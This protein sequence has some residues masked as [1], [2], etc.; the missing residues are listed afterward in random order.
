MFFYYFIILFLCRVSPILHILVVHADY[1]VKI[2]S[3]SLSII[4]RDA[5]I[6]R[7]MALA[8]ATIYLLCNVSFAQIYI[9]MRN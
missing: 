7:P 3:Y 5:L 8:A 6:H 1:G 2:F 9:K 4:T